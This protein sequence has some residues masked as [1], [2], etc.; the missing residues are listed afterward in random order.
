MIGAGLLEALRE[1][2]IRTVSHQPLAPLSTI[3]IGGVAELAVF[4]AS[5][6]EAAFTLDRFRATGTPFRVVGNGSNLLFGD[7]ILE[8]ALLVTRDM[9]RMEWSGDRLYADCGV[10]LS[11]LSASAAKEGYSGLEFARGIPGSLGGAVVMNA[12]AYGGAM[13]DIVTESIAY[14]LR[15]G[16]TVTLTDHGFGYRQSVYLSHS[17]LVCLGVVI[18][19]KKGIREEIEAVMREYTRSRKEK[20]PLEYPSAG[21][22]FKR[23]EGYFAG[24]LIEDCGLKGYRIGNAAVSE[25]HAGFLINLGGATAEDVLRLEEYVRNRV[26]DRFGVELEREVQVML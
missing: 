5:G 15:T 10:S 7:G 17:E 1:R 25:K 8:G 14:D 18:R 4:P 9:S 21:S 2:G 26:R 20:Q 22:Y 13:S 12:G 11:G 3:R 24:K 19:L 16:E 6:E 23:P